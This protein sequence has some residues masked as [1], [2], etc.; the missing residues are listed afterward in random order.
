M[1]RLQFIFTATNEC[2]QILTYHNP[3]FDYNYG[4]YSF[5]RIPMSNTLLINTIDQ[6]SFTQN[7][8]YFTDLS[9][10]SKQ[11]TNV[12]RPDFTINTMDYVDITNQ[13][14]ISN[15]NKVLLAD[16]YS[17]QSVMSLDLQFTQHL[18][19]IPNTKYAVITRWR[20]QLIILD[21][22]QFKIV[23]TLDHS[24]DPDVFFKFQ[25]ISKIYNFTCSTDQVIISSNEGGIIA[26]SINLDTMIG[27][28]HGLID[29]TK[30]NYSSYYN[31]FEKFPGQDIIFVGGQYYEL[32]AIKIQQFKQGQYIKM[33]HTYLFQGLI[34]TFINQI[35]FQY[36]TY[37]SQSQ[38]VLLV[39]DNNY[40]NY[41]DLTV[42]LTNNIITAPYDFSPYYYN[43]VSYY[44]WYQIQGTPYIY[45][46]Y[47]DSATL[48]DFQTGYYHN[49][50]YFRN[51]KYSRRFIYESNGQSLIAIISGQDIYYSQKQSLQDIYDVSSKK[52][53]Y[54]MFFN[55]NS[56][57]KVKNCDDC[58]LV[59]LRDDTNSNTD[60]ISTTKIY[61]MGEKD[62]PQPMTTSFFSISWEQ[63]GNNLD[64]F[65]YN[66]QI[67]VVLAFPK[68]NILNFQVDGLYYLVN[69]QN[70]TQ[71]FVLSSSNQTQNSFNTQ[72]AVASIYDLSNPEII[73]VDQKGNIYS[74]DLLSP[75]FNFKFS[76][77]L[78][79]CFNSQ[80]G[81][82]FQYN[83][84]G[85]LIIA[86]DDYSIYSFDLKTQNQQLLITLTSIPI[87]I[88]AFNSIQMVAIP[89]YI[90]SIL[91]LYKY[92]Q[93]IDTFVYHLSIYQGQLTDYLYHVELLKDNT[94]WV[95]Y[96]YSFIFYPISG[97]LD[98]PTLCTQCSQSYYFNVTNQLDSYGGYGQGSS[99][100]PFTTSIN[101]FQTIINAQ[102]YKSTIKGINNIQVFI[103]ID[104]NNPFYLISQL[105]N[106]SFKS[107][108]SLTISS[109][110]DKQ[111][112]TIQYQNSLI[113]E[114][115]NSINLLNIQVLFLNT[116]INKCGLEFSNIQ[117]VVQINNIQL[118]AYQNALISCQSLIINNTYVQI[119]NYTI[120]SENFANNYF[121]FSTLN[122]NQISIANFTLIN[123]S[124]G[125]QFSILQQNTD[126]QAIVQNIVLENNFCSQINSAFS[127]PTAL[128]SAGHYT[129]SSV[130]IQN[131]TFCNKNIFQAITSIKHSIQTFSFQNIYLISNQF[132]TRTNYLL[133]NCFYSILSD[134]S[135]QL[136]LQNSS[137]QN[138]SLITQSQ[139]DLKGASFIQ[140]NKIQNI[141]IENVDLVDHY[142]I[143]LGAF[144]ESQ[145][146]SVNN[147][148]CTNSQ[149]FLKQ[150]K[151]QQTQGCIQINEAALVILNT[152]QANFKKVQD[153]SLF[154]IS[155]SNYQQSIVNISNAQ[156]TNLILNQTQMN[157]FA[158][159]LQ[160]I[161]SYQINLNIQNS[162][163]VNN[164]LISLQ[165]SLTYSTTGLWFENFV[166]KAI[167]FNTAFE[168]NYSNSIYNNIRIQ[169]DSLIINSC[170]FLN[171]TFSEIIL[172]E[173]K[174]NQLFTQQG[175]M[176]NGVI[177]S[178]IITNSLFKQS[179][180]AIGSFLYLQSFGQNLNL[181][182]SITKFIEGYSQIDGGAMYLNPINSLLNFSCIDCE[183]RN[184]YSLNQ[185]S[186]SI[187][188]IQQNQ[189]NGT[190]NFTFI[191]GIIQTIQGIYDNYFIKATAS[192]IQMINIGQITNQL[193]YSNSIPFL[194][195]QAKQNRQQS[196]LI[197]TQLSQLYI[198]NCNISN[199]S[200]TDQQSLIPLIIQSQNSTITISQTSFSNC[201]YTT[202]IVQLNGGNLILDNILFK[203]IQQYQST[204]ILSNDQQLM[205]NLNQNAVLVIS[206]AQIQ[207]QNNSSFSNISCSSCNGGLLQMLNGNIN[208]QNS[209]FYSIKSQYGG[210]FFITGLHG[211]NQII[212]SIFEDC[213]SFYDGG[214]SYIQLN[215]EKQISLNVDSANFM[216]NTS[217][218]GRGG[219]IYVFSQN[220]NPQFV[221]FSISNSNFTN[222][223]AQ[224]G[225]AIFE[226]NISLQI[227]NSLFKDNFAKI[228]GRDKISYA[229]KLKL[230][231]L[232]QFIAKYNAKQHD[233]Y[234]E[235]NDF[236]SGDQI[237]NISF[238]MMNSFG[239]ILF[240]VSKQELLAYSVQIA[241]TQSQ[242]PTLL[243]QHIPRLDQGQYVQNIVKI[244]NTNIMVVNTLQYQSQDKSIVYFIDMMTIPSGSIIQ[245]TQ[246]SFTAQPNQQFQVFA[247]E[248]SQDIIFYS[249]VGTNKIS[250]FLIQNSQ[251]QI[252]AQA[253]GDYQIKD[254]GLIAQIFC[255]D[256]QQIYVLS[257]NQLFT[258]KFTT[259]TSEPLLQ[260]Q[261][262]ET[263][264]FQDNKQKITQAYFDSYHFIIVSQDTLAQYNKISLYQLSNNS[265]IPNILFFDSK[266]GYRQFIYESNSIIY[267]GFFS[268]QNLFKVY[269]RSS[270]TQ[271]Q[272]NQQNEQVQ[273]PSSLVLFDNNSSLYP[274]KNKQYS[275]LVKAQDTN[276]KPYA[277]IIN[278]SDLSTSPQNC[279]IDQLQNW[280][281]M[282]LD[283]FYYNSHYYIFI[284]DIAN[285]NTFL[286]IQIDGCISL[287][288]ASPFL[289]QNSIQV[290]SNQG[291]QVYFISTQ[292]QFAVWK[293]SD[294]IFQTPQQTTDQISQSNC[295]QP[296]MAEEFQ[297]SSTEYLLIVGCQNKNLVFQ[298]L[299]TQTSTIIQSM[300][301]DTLFIKSF[302]TILNQ[303]SQSILVVGGKQSN[304]VYVLQFNKI[305]SSF[306]IIL[307][308]SS[309]QLQ[310]TPN[311][312]DLLTDQTLWI[313][314]KYSNMFYPLQN[315]LQ[316]PNNCQICSLKVS[317]SEQPQS[318]QY[319]LNYGANNQYQTGSSIMV[320]LLQ[321]KYYQAIQPL[322]IQVSLEIDITA[323]TIPTNYFNFDKSS[324]IILKFVGS[325]SQTSII[326]LQSQTMLNNYQSLSISNIEFK[327][328]TSKQ[329]PNC[330]LIFQ[331]IQNISLNSIQITTDTNSVPQNQ[332]CY[333]L[334][335]NNTL[336]SNLIFNIT[337][338][339]IQNLDF[340]NNNQII[341]S[342]GYKIEVDS[343]TLSGCVL[344]DNFS[345]ITQTQGSQISLSNSQIYNNKC[346]SNWSSGMITSA[347]FQG[348]QISVNTLQILGNTF[349]NK[350]I[351]QS[352][353]V[354]NS[355][356]AVG[357]LNTITVKN[358][359][360]AT[361][362][363]FIFY[364]TFQQQP[365][366]TIQLNQL[367]FEQNTIQ[368]ISKL[369]YATYI[370]LFNIQSVTAAQIN[371]NQ[372]YSFQF[373]NLTSINSLSFASIYFQNDANF[374]TSIASRNIPSCFQLYE[375]LAA[376]LNDIK[377]L[378]KN[379]VDQPLILIKNIQTQN[380]QI[381][382]SK[383]EF[384]NLNLNQPQ[385]NTNASPIQVSSVLYLNLTLDN[386]V[387][388][389]NNLNVNSFPSVYSAS[390]L[391]IE[392]QL[393]NN[394]IQNSQLLNTYSNSLYNFI[395]CFGNNV[396]INACSF[397]NSSFVAQPESNLFLQ[398]GGMIHIKTSNLNIY[399]SNFTQ[400]TAFKGSFMYVK[401]I[402][403]PTSVNIQQTN[404]T[405]GYAFLD[406]GA[407]YFD[408]LGVQLV[409]SCKNCLFKNIFT[410]YMGAAVV[411]FEPQGNIQIKDLNKIT[412]DG[413]SILNMYGV[414]D[415]SFIETYYTNIQILNIQ[416]IG[417]DND[418]PSLSTAYS[419][420]QKMQMQQTSFLNILNGE[421]TI[422][423]CGISNFQIKNSDSTYS[424]FVTSVNSKITL[425]T[426]VIKNSVFYQNAFQITK[427]STLNLINT[428]I[429]NVKQYVQS[430]RLLQSL[431]PTYTPSQ[432]SFS[433]IEV[434]GS[435][436]NISN[437]SQISQIVCISN[438]NGI[439]QITNSSM[440]ADSSTI[441]L[442]QSNFGGAIYVRSFTGTNIWNSLILDQNS[443][444][445]DGGALYFSVLTND[446]FKLALNQ[447]TIS[448]NKSINGRGGG[449]YITSQVSNT[450]NQQ[451]VLKDTKV[452]KNNAKVG[453]GMQFSNIS[454]QIKGN[455]VF[456]GNKAFYFGSDLF[457]YPSHLYLQ[458][459][460]QTNNQVVINQFRSGGPLN[461]LT[462]EFQNDKNEK[463]LPV[464]LL[465]I[466]SYSIQ[467]LIDPNNQ[468]FTKYTIRGD[469]TIFYSLKTQSFTFSQLIFV[470]TPGT[471]ANIQF[472]SDKIQILDKDTNTFLNNY[473]FNMLINFRACESGEE[474]KDYNQLVECAVCPKGSYSFHIE[475][476]VNCPDGAICNGGNNVT[477]NQGFWRK[478][479]D[480]ILVENCYNLPANCPGGSYGN[481]VCFEGHIGALCEE[482]D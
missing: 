100:N 290:V 243:S 395:Y 214:V 336:G 458:N 5:L 122:T 257:N 181:L 440:N 130:L 341:L 286:L 86:C 394:T 437:N 211:T 30:S 480:S 176:I 255:L 71:F 241:H 163:F 98:D 135:H 372:E 269:I 368:Q 403:N 166:G 463:I 452:L 459:Y 291:E 283:P 13:I 196:T 154:L 266:I 18:F 178:I 334:I 12:V 296:L 254:T 203:D 468:N 1:I 153:N 129:V 42:D 429:T 416:Q 160:I 159:P 11:I 399:Q 329:Y 137:F 185:Q 190:N 264:I 197:Y 446:K 189:K 202:N 141:T 93:N 222:N 371:V 479:F 259:S 281:D 148:N 146:I 469:D 447:C 313:Q 117:N 343:L 454:P 308:I 388:S 427:G 415:N 261:P 306:E 260:F 475:P 246:P 466:Q 37:N 23:K 239:E 102:F 74:W 301:E 460:T 407:F 172:F 60:Y 39:A 164:S 64:P 68:K 430:S 167:I 302:S 49:Q 140:T 22:L 229:T 235:I 406:G 295:D 139:R 113:F 304:N 91:Y 288:F 149:L 218:N 249:V 382:F 45:M 294:I 155:N 335:A 195:Y 220:L 276:Q 318:N 464:S 481:N 381:S 411:G 112:A 169:T 210:V 230:V 72:F 471:S 14:L 43:I 242:C 231:N 426:V 25:Y 350:L 405:E 278:Q 206:N 142:D 147:F 327:F 265:Q 477:A 451:I 110:S 396:T 324:N 355:G 224:I 315:C 120:N 29:F 180:A 413:G 310:D 392:N 138:N 89:D 455:T 445:F 213:Q 305:N 8:V 377:A 275:I 94:I 233:D 448:N 393:G 151:D 299:Q 33:M 204:Q 253:Q 279:Q 2:P 380:S 227:N 240:P 79:N 332:N 116:N 19:V 194:I 398:R 161:G 248:V 76:L 282:K 236:R 256:N 158:N 81:E 177:N 171:S 228:F 47:K 354:I 397:Q 383:G 375:I 360:F 268:E 62:Y 428:Q 191:R 31:H 179:T 143:Q 187:Q 44:Q 376:N 252:S 128:F 232:E 434:D 80:I 70:T 444:T 362:S 56:F 199:L 364:Y 433:L 337:T 87:S 358:N 152:V 439:I 287:S 326:S 157:T 168:N 104:P 401:S 443:A 219:A 183:F 10:P 435:T 24:N 467:V 462:F 238:K 27:T 274:I 273:L 221:D 136:I 271:N 418:T 361:I 26:W 285:Q 345:I 346:T 373:A 298:N 331:D 125:D 309:G 389:N 4:V 369:Q 35:M 478:K 472:R 63:I 453:G 184:I 111:L 292:G 34:N 83:T 170:I 473:A 251:Q 225:G 85:K 115:Y 317:I 344:G 457:S 78:K 408:N 207:I 379:S 366:S 270:N 363:P 53:S 390:A 105:T 312:V 205:T 215:D 234:L 431:V 461:N 114:D 339:N 182:I 131:N 442:S 66:N 92:N 348:S 237:T 20:N 349:C 424:L 450:P 321:A 404:F 465:D 75:T 342:N 303:Q 101:Y 352:L 284:R 421:A 73:G 134:P 103:E 333:N 59:K 50:L 208:I 420:Y 17:F 16:P 9:S 48:F 359:Q 402:G 262:N 82:I 316:S 192:Q 414:Q 90:G 106:F 322:Q 263:S 289:D 124:F 144:D 250:S 325:T 175:G 41:V 15:I 409:F 367:T 272:Q 340:T 400:A 6:T 3:I 258:V 46:S 384:K 55:L 320:T 449:M 385:F 293:I 226:Q 88:R 36:I 21:V 387:F 51:D 370:S 54:K 307:T 119:Q 95:Q 69:A 156:F 357:N 126:V 150:L 386:I 244:P 77:Q 216:N 267:Y 193:F 432:Q 97:C 482:C 121:I 109:I 474:I 118:I 145:F 173:N 245:I 65:Y 132:L 374:Q 419:M 422:Q 347:L 378:Y 470:G 133:F 212:N 280:N 127:N 423:N 162:Q 391:W 201:E 57:Y 217:I 40:I 96:K 7:V 438:C 353:Q 52:F 476:C 365:I 425:D 319:T 165:Y 297:L 356:I 108:I 198:N 436:L 84:I 323:A 186:S 277:V 311:Y 417:L 58:L 200:I 223:K 188:I 174:Y 314:Y 338:M 107:L 410:L 38:A 300:I 456:Q 441:S 209:L 32:T 330:G 351:F 247:K 99:Q 328:L 123:C 67:W 412:F 61:P 28:Y